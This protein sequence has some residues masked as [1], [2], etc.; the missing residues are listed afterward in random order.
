MPFTP[1]HFGF[2]IFLFS[3]FTFLDPIA[4]LIGCVIIDLEPIFYLLF[5]VGELHGIIHSFLGV[6]IFLLPVSLLSWLSFRW[7]NLERYF[8]P[9]N[10]YISLLSGLVGLVS[11]IFFDTII[12]SEMMLWFPFSREQ[13][14]FYGLWSSNTD[15]I[16][17]TAMLG[18]GVVILCARFLIK[19]QKKKKLSD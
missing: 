19:K 1:F 3:I 12:Y 17:L 5:G 18:A 8:K 7:F 15:Y 14:V 6:I 9:F 16:I 4:L 11:H 13:G 10:P 2:A